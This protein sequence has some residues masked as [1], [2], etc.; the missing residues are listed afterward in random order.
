MS[1]RIEGHMVEIMCEKVQ[2]LLAFREESLRR[3]QIDPAHER[4]FK[5]IFDHKTPQDW[6][7]FPNWLMSTGECYWINGKAGSGKSTLTKYI[8]D[9]P[10]LLMCV[11]EGI[12]KRIGHVPSMWRCRECKERGPTQIVLASHFFW[13]AGSRLQKD[14]EG[15]LRSL[16]RQILKARPELIRVLFPWFPD[17]MSRTSTMPAALQLDELRQ[18]F[19]LLKEYMPDNLQ[20]L[21]LVDGVD[22]FSGDYFELSRFLLRVSCPAIKLLVSSRPIPEC[23]Q[24]FNKF[25]SLQLE[26]LTTNDIHSY[27]EAEFTSH[28]ICKRMNLRDAKFSDELT[29]IL[30]AK[31]SGVF[32]WIVLVVRRMIMALANFDSKAQLLVLIDELPTDL[33]ELY[34]HMFARMS[35]KYR[36][37]GA[38]LLQLFLHA[39]RTQQN[40]VT[41]LQFYVADMGTGIE[42]LSLT[43]ATYSKEEEILR[44]DMVEGRLRSRCC[45][46]LEVLSRQDGKE[47]PRVRV[48]YLHLTVHDYLQDGRI[49]EKLAN[50]CN[51]TEDDINIRLLRA[52]V[53]VMQHANPGMIL[54]TVQ[55]YIPVCFADCLKYSDILNRAENL[56]Y[57]EYLYIAEKN[58]DMTCTNH[59]YPPG[60][61]IQSDLRPDFHDSPLPKLFQSYAESGFDLTY[62]L[63]YEPIADEAAS[64]LLI[65]CMR[66]L[67]LTS[68]NSIAAKI[69]RRQILALIQHSKVLHWPVSNDII[70]G[71]TL[72]EGGSYSDEGRIQLLNRFTMTPFA[73]WI[74]S[75]KARP[76][77]AE[78]TLAVFKHDLKPTESAVFVPYVFELSILLDKVREHSRSC[79]QHDET[80]SLKT[81]VPQVQDL[82]N[83]AL[84]ANRLMDAA[85]GLKPV[86]VDPNGTKERKRKA[87]HADLTPDIDDARRRM[88]ID[89][90]I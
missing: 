16:L 70:P 11:Q 26:H 55:P 79:T 46:L 77:Y 73:W 60:W 47:L 31:A 44:V 76:E 90:L 89:F 57:A 74:H 35:H 59:G 49:Q 69:R 33:E 5:W 52:C 8:L 45:G 86:I 27:I 42:D 4:T 61:K 15:V 23:H 48:E 51:A 78:L 75:Y 64:V 24:I 14:S 18:A 82:Y 25:P 67:G 38:L 30:I 34:D 81:L 41:A 58:Y 7:P 88:R 10:E 21:L 66:W 56:A 63:K 22:E 19:V 50:L 62:R 39:K 2:S 80:E 28:P 29:K 83:K 6:S 54:G 43:A 87:S 85:L 32:L 36:Q 53:H 17:H 1:S 20:I 84:D 72:S 65:M 71:I 37:E 13:Y 12:C 3:F 68:T 9:H 40:F